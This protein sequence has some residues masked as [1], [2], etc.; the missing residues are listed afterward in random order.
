MPMNRSRSNIL[1]CTGAGCVA[2][3]ALELSAALREALQRFKL[4]GEVKVIETGCL[5]PCAVGPVAVSIPTACSTRTSS[6]RTRTASSRSTCSRAASWRTTSIPC[7]TSPARS[8]ACRTS[9][10][11][12][13][14]VKIVLRNCGVIDPLKIEEYIARDGYQALAKVLTEMTPE[15]VIDAVKSS[16]L[17]GRGGAGF[18]TGL[19]WDFCRKASGREEVRPLQRRRGRP[20]RVHGPQRPGRRPAQR[21]RG[22]GHRR[23]RHRRLAGLR[24]RAR[25]VSA[26]RRAAGQGP[27][28]GARAGA[29]GQEHPGHRLRLRHRDPHG[30]RRVR[31]RRG[32]R[33]DDL[34]RGQPRRA[35]APA[36]RSRPTRACGTSPACSTTSRPSPT[37]R[38]SS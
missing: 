35:A 7:T 27:R 31:L 38:R 10:F 5:G 8:P 3:G 15:Q 20:G 9:S 14:Q 18:P 12:R 2:S 32:D 30:L 19:K 22:H 4:A 11:F 24:L 37:S 34:H 36:R 28:P 26:G 29:A 23:L 17:R 13:N 1:V 16:G 33:A 6:R 21:D 25:R